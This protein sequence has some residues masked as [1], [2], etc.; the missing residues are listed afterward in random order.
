MQNQILHEVVITAIVV[1]DDKYLIIKRSVKE[2]RFPGYWTV[3]GGKLETNDY[4][5]YPKETEHYWYNVLEK[6]LRQEV[7]DEVSVEIENID[8]VT[9]LARVHEDGAPSLVIS[10]MADYVSGDIKLQE[11]EA[12]DYKWVSL[13]EAK[14]YKLIDGI[15]DELA[16]AENRRKGIKTEWRRDGQK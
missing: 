5:K 16:M 2:K 11:D 13:E 1:K 12:D 8:Y 14:K 15:F 3:P 6:V 7:R 9:S 10:C 4:T